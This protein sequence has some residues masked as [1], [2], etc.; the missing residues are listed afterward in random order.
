MAYGLMHTDGTYGYPNDKPMLFGVGML[1]FYM[2]AAFA[3]LLLVLC[4]ERKRWVL[5]GALLLN[6]VPNLYFSV[7]GAPRDIWRILALFLAM[8]YFAGLRPRG[9][10]YA[11]VGKLLATLLVCFLVMSAHVVCFVVLP[12]IVVAWVLWRWYAGALGGKGRAGKE[13]LGSIGLALGG[14]VGT[15]GGFA[16]NLWC[17]WKWGEMSPFRIMTTYTTAP[18]YSMYMASE[19]KLE[20]TTTHVNFW[21]AYQDI[22][23]EYA[24]PIGIWGLRLALIGLACAV[25]YLVWRRKSGTRVLTAVGT[26]A[27]SGTEGG[28]QSAKALVYGAL[29][30]VCTLAPMSG[31]L[32]SPLYSFS[33][34]FLAL[35]RYTLQWF[36]LC[37]VMIAAALAALEGAWP[38]LLA[39]LHKKLQRLY[40][41][42][43][44]KP[45]WPPVRT[46]LRN[47]P[48]LLCA[49]LCVLSFWKGTSQT[50]YDNNFYRYSRAVMEDEATLLDNGFLQRNA[51][52]MT[53]GKHAPEGEKILL[54]RMGYQYP[55]GAKGYILTSNPIVPLMNL[56]LGEVP[57]EL[58]AMNVCM[59][60]TEAEF[61]D[62][63]YFASSTLSEYLNALPDGQILEDG[64]MRIYVLDAAL[65]QEI[66]TEWNAAVEKVAAPQ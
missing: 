38:T 24:T 8:L 35:Q 36:M 27:V 52:L 7:N 26:L 15:L 21:Q 34:S 49:L 12:F 6:L 42:L 64:G 50:G 28:K 40:A 5:L 2:V 31:L 57:D 59:L 4:R 3:A 1:T 54:T 9:P 18:W 14:A 13:L 11:Y 29:L 53:A 45:W 33:G 25:A 37:A 32:D 46:A 65:A 62:E 41:S 66:S 20:E 23:L 10:W 60:A 63:R 61:W 47:A 56:P 39:W 58:E 43:L 55:L 51:L 48:A 17:Y 16:G 30:T 22:V 44:K 19:Y